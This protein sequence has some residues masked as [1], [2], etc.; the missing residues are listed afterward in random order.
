MVVVRRGRRLRTPYLVM[1]VLRSTAGS[2]RVACVVGKKVHRTAV[3]RHRIQ[4]QMREIAQQTIPSLSRSH[5][6]VWVALP[7]AASVKT[8]ARLGEGIQSA[9]TALG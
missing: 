3:V 8:K 1:Y 6:M 4:R 2:S 9:L 7:S 5:D